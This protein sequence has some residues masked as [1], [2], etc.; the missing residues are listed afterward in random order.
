MKALS[1]KVKFK[2]RGGAGQ[3]EGGQRLGDGQQKA[4]VGNG[5]SVTVST[6]KLF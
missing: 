6:I 2:N 5:T 4:E 3:R 1:V